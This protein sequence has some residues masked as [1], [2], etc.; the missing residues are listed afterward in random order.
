MK[1]AREFTPCTLRP[2]SRLSLLVS[3]TVAGVFA[4]LLSP[5]APAG[6]SAAG[7]AG[8]DPEIR[9]LPPLAGD[10]WGR[11]NAM[12]NRG[13]VIGGSWNGTGDGIETVLWRDTGPPV[14]LGIGGAVLADGG[15]TSSNPSDVNE[16]GLIAVNVDRYDSRTRVQRRSAFLWQA[17]T[18][19][20]LPA[21]AVRPWSG[22]SDLN[23]NGVAVGVIYRPDETD[24][25]PVVWRDGQLDV[26]PLP[27]GATGGAAAI[28]NTGLIVGFV[29]RRGEPFSPTTPWWW[30]GRRAA[31]C[32]TRKAGFAQRRRWTTATG[33]SAGG[34]QGR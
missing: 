28:N 31:P 32:R 3:V 6:G 17:G 25:I 13:W 18:K 24:E 21:G 33:S 34:E 14:G 26:L 9:T 15:F 12:N 20:R 2:R 4:A 11:V 22:V 10:A 1:S 16:D 7:I 19:L 30:R 23:D 27:R 8:C 5:I 29:N